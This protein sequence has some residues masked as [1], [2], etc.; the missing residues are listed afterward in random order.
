[1]PPLFDEY[2]DPYWAACVERNIT[3]VVHAGFGT[4]HGKAFPQVERIYRDVERA[5][6][7]TDME[8]LHAHADAVSDESLQFFHDFLNHNVDSRRPMW[9]MM[10]GGVFDRHPDLRLLLA[11]VR[12]DWLPAT[13]AHLDE[14]FEQ[15]LGD[16]PGQRRPSEYWHDNCLA[17]LSF[18][19]KAEVQM[20]HE[21]GLETITFG[22]DYPHTEG[23]WPNTADWLSD[24][25]SG[26]PEDELRMILGENAIR[27]FDLDGAH[28][29]TI[30]ERIGPTVEHVNGRTLDLD[31]RML[32]NWDNRGGYLKPPEQVNAAAIDEL[33]D[34][35]LSRLAGAM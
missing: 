4:E 22:R 21:I 8:A 3:I 15:A 13:L 6:G 16:V 25:F 27:F 10:L 35:D 17:A 12:A 34:E 30:A 31:E 7:S 28:L 2:W 32:G 24:A 11:E 26:V 9:Q 19:H 18:V 14:A 5:A 23:T 1:M 33:L 29:A 20:R